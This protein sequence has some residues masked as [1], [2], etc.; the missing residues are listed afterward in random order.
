MFKSD[1]YP[2]AKVLSKSAKSTRV[3]DIGVGVYPSKAILTNVSVLGER[4]NAS[5]IYLSVIVPAYNV[6]KDIT[7]TLHR[8]QEYFSTQP[9]TYEIIVAT[10]GPRDNTIEIAKNLIPEIKN[11]KVLERHK[12]RGKGFTVREGM[13]AASGRI[14]L[15]M[16]AD[17]GTDIAHFDK[18][19]SFFDR[20]YEVVISSR[21]PRDAPG[22]EEVRQPW[23]R[24]LF[25]NVGNLIIQLLT[26][27]GIWDTQNGF[28]AFRDTAAERIFKMAKIN[29]W[30]FDVEVLA[31]AQKFDYKIGIVSARWINSA[32]SSIKLSSYIHFLW[33]VV[34][35][36]WY[37]SR[38]KYNL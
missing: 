20:G 18:M 23:W 25:G 21:D 35:I 24:R 28:K 37:L 19:R 30:A 36:R 11:L 6:S 10:D 15:F 1:I 3:V 14:R 29:R 38:R 22:G 2:H 8:L 7:N 34:K 17:N 31:L 33:E 27:R 9:F 13:L 5:D 26:V 32:Q 4:K 16:D 12:N